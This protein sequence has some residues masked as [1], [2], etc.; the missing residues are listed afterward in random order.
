M[1]LR[2]LA[3]TGFLMCAVSLAPLFA[4]H[5]A[6]ARM[7]CRDRIR[8]EE[9][10]VDEAVRRHGEHSRQAE[11]ERHKLHRLREKCGMEHR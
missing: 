1:R 8:Q 3:R 7:D 6:F 2:S 5:T 10:R 9:H 11:R 4:S